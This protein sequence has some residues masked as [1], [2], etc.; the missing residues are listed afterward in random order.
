MADPKLNWNLADEFGQTPLIACCKQK[1][2]DALEAN[3]LFVIAKLLLDHPGYL[4]PLSFHSLS[5]ITYYFFIL[6]P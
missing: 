1:G 6:M 5:S 3:T 2:D 4:S